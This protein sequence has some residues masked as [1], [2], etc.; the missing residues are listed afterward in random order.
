MKLEQGGEENRNKER[1]G[2]WK[3][4]GEVEEETN[5]LNSTPE[6]D[7]ETQRNTAMPFC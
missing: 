5:V 1:Y 2:P 4:N 7:S 6:G 3:S